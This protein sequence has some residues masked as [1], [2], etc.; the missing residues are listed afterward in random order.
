MPFFSLIVPCIIVIFCGGVANSEEVIMSTGE[1]LTASSVWEV[2]G[3]VHIN[4][5]GLIVKVKKDDVTA[6][7]KS[8]VDP[9][10]TSRLA[11]KPTSSSMEDSRAETTPRYPAKTSYAENQ[12]GSHLSKRHGEKH[13]TE[14]DA[15]I[16]LPEI[17]WQMNP[18]QISGLKK[19]HTDPAFGGIDQY[20]QPDRPLLFGEALLNGWVFGFWQGQLY[21][22]MLW[23]NGKTSYEALRH[24]VFTRYGPGKQSTAHQECFIWD[25]RDTQRML[26]YDATLQSALFVMRSTLMDAYIKQ[27]YPAE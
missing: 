25:G 8:T 10:R 16:G 5:Q 12:P 22:I 21:S 9:P 3:V 14:Y 6:I 18:D 7:I 20:T 17:F 19:I 27:L 15:S 26:Q 2:D 24:E 1:H 4:M 11:D 23:T 13:R